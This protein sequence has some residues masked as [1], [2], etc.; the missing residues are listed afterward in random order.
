MFD[1]VIAA[2]GYSSRMGKWKL[3]MPWKGVPLV[4]HVMNN[5][6]SA[7]CRVIAAG[8]YNFENLNRIITDC[9]FMNTDKR[10]PENKI[11]IAFAEDWECGMGG[12]VRSV[13]SLTETNWIFVT[14]ADMPLIKKED[15][16]K[17]QSI[18][19]SGRYSGAH[20]FRPAWK[21]K[22]GHP[23]LMGP[24]VIKGILNN[25]PGIPLRKILTNY[26]TVEIDWDHGGVADDIDTPEKYRDLIASD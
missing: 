22:P 25:P 23:V 4:V 18:Y 11:I 20:A 8:G 16:E 6:L 3:E 5:A 24:D 13:I 10:L 2:A 15:Y 19:R 26:S 9:F 14:P 17:L 7:G 12:S 21:G 1:C